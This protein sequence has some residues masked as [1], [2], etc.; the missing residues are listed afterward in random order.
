M[1][2]KS[3]FRVAYD[4]FFCVR[5]RQGAILVLVSVCKSKASEAEK[6]Q[7]GKTQET[8]SGMNDW[9]SARIQSSNYRLGYSALY[10][11]V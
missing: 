4:D 6:K 3:I 1:R 9:S 11:P 5:I 8:R 10:A 7:L 2:T